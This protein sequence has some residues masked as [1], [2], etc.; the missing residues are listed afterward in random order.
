[1]VI[2]CSR[3]NLPIGASVSSSVVKGVA[4]ALAPIHDLQPYTAG[5]LELIYVEGIQM[6]FMCRTFSTCCLGSVAHVELAFA[7]PDKTITDIVDI[8]GRD[9]H[10]LFDRNFK[11]IISTGHISTPAAKKITSTGG[12]RQGRFC[13]VN[14]DATTVGKTMTIRI[15]ININ[16]EMRWFIIDKFSSNIQRL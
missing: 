7:N 5:D 2:G 9:V 10:I 4:I 15:N 13:P 11:R 8:I 6:D 1:M 14:K 12:C 16:I 3:W